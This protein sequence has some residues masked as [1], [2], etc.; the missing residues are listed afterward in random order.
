MHPPFG[1][2]TTS[3]F[4]LSADVDVSY[5]Y[6]VSLA[7]LEENED[8]LEV[9]MNALD[10]S[11]DSLPLLAYAIELATE[12]GH[13]STAVSLCARW[14]RLTSERPVGLTDRPS[15]LADAI[16]RG[17]FREEGVREVLGILNSIQRRNRVRGARSSLWKDPTDPTSILY[18]RVVHAPPK[19]AAKMNEEFADR[20]AERPDLLDDPGP[21]CVPMSIGT[22]TDAGDS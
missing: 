21:R 19:R 3:R 6:A 8:A 9:V 17:A 11:P 13:I 10:R 2:T 4:R 16:E 7:L 18:E 20:I 14:D 5:N 1:T 12:S 22:H 15:E